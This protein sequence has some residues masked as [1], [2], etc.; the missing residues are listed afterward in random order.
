MRISLLAFL[1]TF[2]LN[3]QALSSTQPVVVRDP[4]AVAL[5]QQSVAAMGVLPSDSTAS[6]NVTIVAGSSAQ[7]GSIQILTR[8]TT[9]TS[10]AVQAGSTN[11]SVIFSGG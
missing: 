8:G 4:Q 3:S 7:Q 1:I 10:V 6:G 2:F 11:W 9:Q 5:L